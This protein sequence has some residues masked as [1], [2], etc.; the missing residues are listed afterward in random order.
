MLKNKTSLFFLV[1]G[2][3]LVF[4]QLTKDLFFT[5]KLKLNFGVAL[6]LMPG[7]DIMII[8]FLII[9]I[10]F[11][12]RSQIKRMPLAFGLFFGG[13]VSNL[14]DRFIYGGV[15]DFLPIPLTNLSNNL[16]D[17]A[18]VIGIGL[19]LVQS[20]RFKNKDLGLKNKKD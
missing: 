1:A 10:T 8:G 13:A 19:I 12:F 4:D 17:W 16:A 6:G 7:I 20:L 2:S 9:L 11:V 18:I 3:V 15:R 14:L 5:S